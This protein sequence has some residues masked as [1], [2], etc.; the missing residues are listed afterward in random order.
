ME[1]PTMAWIEYAGIKNGYF[2]RKLFLDNDKQG[3]KD[4][5]TACK[6]TDV[7]QCIYTYSS[8]NIDQALLTGPFYLDFDTDIDKAQDYR[9]LRRQVVRSM[10]FIRDYLNVPIVAQRLYFSGYKGF[11][12]LIPEVVW[13][14][15]PM[16]NLNEKYK[17]LMLA[18]KKYSNA[19]FLD[20]QI[21]DRRRVFRLPNSINS[22]SGLYKIAI[23]KEEVTTYSLEQIRDLAQKKRFLWTPRPTVMKDAQRVWNKLFTQTE[24]PKKEKLERKKI[25]VKPQGL[26]PCIKKILKTGISEGQRNNTTVALANAL[27][28]SGRDIDEVQQL[29]EEWNSVNDPPLPSAELIHTIISARHMAESD[30]TYGCPSM[31]ELGFCESSCKLKRS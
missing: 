5:L 2:R 25:P 14:N 11:H 20:T 4:F 9:I 22:K 17:K 18:I 15:Q 8:E 19:T 12:L 30:K 29:L 13:S 21:Y 24:L 6:N 3:T 7:Y 26:L 27:F 28:Q 23:T 10:N 1:A 31:Q 16:Y